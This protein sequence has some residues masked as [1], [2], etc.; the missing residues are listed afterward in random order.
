MN[1]SHK[2]FTTAISMLSAALLSA[3]L[4]FTAVPRLHGETIDR[5][6]RRIAHTEHQLHEA[7]EHHGRN[8]RQADHRRHELHEARE[9]CWREQHRWWDEHDHR[10]H[11]ERDWNEHDHD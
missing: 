10:W 3:V 2:L 4:L 11:T 8:S 7:I 6:Q 5:C 9:R 1:R